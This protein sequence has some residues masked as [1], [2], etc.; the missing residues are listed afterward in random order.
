MIRFEFP[1]TEQVRTWLR[2]EAAWSRWRHFAQ[3]NTPDDHHAALMALFECVDIAGRSDLKR[4]LIAALEALCAAPTAQETTS[5][6]PR[7]IALHEPVAQ[8]LALIDALRQQPGRID[9]VMRTQPL[10]NA[11]RTRA[12]VSG[13][14]CAFDLPTYHF[15]L[16]LS[17]EK[18]RADLDAW[19]QPL[20]PLL[21]AIAC[22]LAHLRAQSTP[23]TH[24]AANGCYQQ[25]LDGRLPRLIQVWIDSAHRVVPKVSANKYQFNLHFIPVTDEGGIGTEAVSTQ[26]VPF[27]LTLCY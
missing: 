19:A 11:L 23:Q 24:T 2:L 9:H 10:L 14:V 13:G 12:H 21:D 5:Q 27:A 25:P 17:A 3:A 8:A 6:R 15:W 1:L 4:H 7:R 22:V 16:N 26:T 20:H 18:R